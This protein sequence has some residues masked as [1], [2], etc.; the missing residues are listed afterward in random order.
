M[1][2]WDTCMRIP[3]VFGRFDLAALRSCHTLG[4]RLFV[5]RSLSGNTCSL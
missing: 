5:Q 4:I 1:L 3:G 2:W